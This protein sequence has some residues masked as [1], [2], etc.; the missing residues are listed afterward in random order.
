[1]ARSIFLNKHLTKQVRL[2]LLDAL[3]LPVLM[4]GAGSWS[5]LPPSQYRH[6]QHTIIMWQRRIVNAGFWND[7]DMADHDF[8]AQWKLPPLSV[9]L[10]KHR[11]LLALQL[12]QHAPRELFDL[13]SA[14]DASPHGWIPA[15]R[16][17]LEW[18]ALHNPAHPLAGQDL[19]TEN[20]FAWLAQ[21]PAQEAHL[22]RQTVQRYCLQEHTLWMT[23]SAHRAIGQICEQAGFQLDMP[24]GDMPDDPAVFPCKQRKRTFD[25]PQGLSA[26]LWSAHQLMSLER[27]YVF[28]PTC[29]ICGRCYWTSQR[30]QQ[31]LRYSRKFP[32]GCLSQLVQHFEPLTMPIKVKIPEIYSGIHRLPCTNAEGP[33]ALMPDTCWQRSHARDMARWQEQWATLDMPLQLP[34][35]FN[36]A[37]AAQYSRIT[38]EWL[39]QD[40]PEDVDTLAHNWL[41]CIDATDASNGLALWAFF[42]WGHNFMND[43]FDNVENPELVTA[44]ESTYLELVDSLLEWHLWQRREHLRHASAPAEP[45]LALPPATADRRTFGLLEP[46][47]DAIGDQQRALRRADLCSW[48]SRG[49]VPASALSSCTSFLP[50]DATRIATSGSRL[51]AQ[52]TSLVIRA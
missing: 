18:F 49:G 48:P 31:H 3:I 12:Q 13:L 43:V 29:I 6:V 34:T 1:M 46:F 45:D 4:Y 47:P 17:G 15:L 24:P 52:S 35:D 19:S 28:G 42:H 16:H 7:T 5:L 22:I 41:A 26:H 2:Q 8:L 36:R 30:M 32:D 14:D 37:C 21:A 44:V 23:R 10:A 40:D 50:A 11:L 33:V 38:H 20:I 27:Q 25:T 51:S 9:R 39:D